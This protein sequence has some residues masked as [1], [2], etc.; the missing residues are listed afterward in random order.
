MTSFRPLYRMAMSA[1]DWERSLDAIRTKVGLGPFM[2]LD[3]RGGE[4]TFA[5]YRTK[6]RNAD[7]VPSIP[8]RHVPSAGMD[9]ES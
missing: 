8:L 4:P 2:F 9:R 7:F 3:T 6:V 1:L 5:A